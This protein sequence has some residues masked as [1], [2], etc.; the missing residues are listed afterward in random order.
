MHTRTLMHV[1]Q[2]KM[3]T[4]AVDNY[5]TRLLV[6]RNATRT[7]PGLKILLTS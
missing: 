7:H 1:S 5:M 6:P 4:A 3:G 2:L